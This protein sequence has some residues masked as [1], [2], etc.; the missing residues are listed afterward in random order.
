M[1]QDLDV[2]SNEITYNIYL[3][4]PRRGFIV[5]IYFY[6]E[7]IEC[8]FYD[9]ARLNL[10]AYLNE[11]ALKIIHYTACLTQVHTTARRDL[12]DGSDNSLF[13]VGNLGGGLDCLLRGSSLFSRD[14]ISAHIV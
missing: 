7:K 14:S 6:F 12:F 11:A 3:Y 8:E 5:V 13:S 4:N 2:E 1:Q 10:K 9:L